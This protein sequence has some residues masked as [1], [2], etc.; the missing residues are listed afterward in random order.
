MKR[1]TITAAVLTLN[2]ARQI[3]ELVPALRWCDEVLVLDGG[4]TDGTAEVAERCGARVVA[5]RFDDFARQRNAAVEAAA[6]DWVLFV[7]A[8]E[9]PTTGFADEVRRRIAAEARLGYRVPIR[10][11]IFGRRFRFSGTQNDLPLRLFRRRAGRWIGAVHER[12]AVAGA[13]GRLES[14]LEHATLPT[15]TAF[16]EKMQRYTA[17]TA[18][19]RVE[20]NEPP[21]W[22]ES[23]IRPPTEVFRR[24]IWKQGWLDGP[25]GWAFCFLSGLSEWVLAR[26]HLRM[27]RTAR[28]ASVRNPAA[29]AWRG[30]TA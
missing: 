25:Q 29:T 14:N 9:R 2:E 28:A 11:T 1:P 4:S 30:E 20:R 27:W 12:L 22:A 19:D 8:D 26:H 13:V 23:W 18:A 5:R 17:M 6:G 15:V 7:D 21:R 3:P 16:L 10:S 24:L